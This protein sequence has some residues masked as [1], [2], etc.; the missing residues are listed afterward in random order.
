MNHNKYADIIHLPHRQSAKRPHM[1]RIDRAAQFA[2]FAALTG[3]DDAI[4]ETGRRTDE[5]TVLSEETLNL[6]NRKFQFLLNQTDAPGEVILTFFRPDEEKS[7]GAY[8]TV[9][10]VLK[11]VDLYKRLIT[12]EDGTKIPMDDISAVDGEIFTLFS[13]DS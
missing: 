1:P 9:R 12:M 7:G 11:K 13:L 3:Y 5:K 6:L 10:G 4:R 8:V 2:P